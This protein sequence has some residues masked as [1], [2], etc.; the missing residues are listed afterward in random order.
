MPMLETLIELLAAVTPEQIAQSALGLKPPAEGERVIGVV[1]EARTKAL[2]A[3]AHSLDGQSQMYAH[4]A[5][6]DASTQEERDV[7][8]ALS[9]KASLLEELARDI[10]WLEMRHEL[11]AWGDHLGLRADFTLVQ[12]PCPTGQLDITA[13]PIPIDRIVEEIMKVRSRKREPEPPKGKPQ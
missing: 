6:F 2:W 11:D 10:G 13:F 5:K 12:T 3:L 1:Q 4:S 9:N 7:F 8:T